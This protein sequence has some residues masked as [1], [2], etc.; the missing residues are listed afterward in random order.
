MPAATGRMNAARRSRRCDGASASAGGSRNVRANSLESRMTRKDT[1]ALEC[2]RRA[3]Q[4][5]PRVAR[6]E[7]FARERQLDRIAARS[8]KSSVGPAPS[9]FA[10]AL[11]AP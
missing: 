2:G 11:N 5:V 7:P 10:N 9:D 1:E 4:L 8:W 6:T 3:E